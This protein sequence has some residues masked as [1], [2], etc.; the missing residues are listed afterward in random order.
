MLFCFLYILDHSESIDIQIKNNKKNSDFK[1]QNL[2]TCLQLIGVFVVDTFT[3]YSL[4][5]KNI[6][7]SSLSSPNLIKQNQILGLIERQTHK[8][9]IQK[10]LKLNLAWKHSPPSLPPYCLYFEKQYILT[11]PWWFSLAVCHS[12]DQ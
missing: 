12:Y 2:Q 4:W 5:R 10:N 9:I 6:L 11:I 7:W 3:L 1:S 8:L